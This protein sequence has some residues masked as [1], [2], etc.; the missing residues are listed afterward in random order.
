MADKLH[1]DKLTPRQEKAII[2][3]LNEPSIRKAA[4]TADVPERTLYAWLK[5]DQTFNDAYYA[6]RREAMSQA[7]ARLQQGST[8]AVN[9][10][11][12]IMARETTPLPL[13]LS[14]AKAVLDYAYRGT[15]LE[16]LAMRVALL[17]ALNHEL[18]NA[19]QS[20]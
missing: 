6:A 14:A 17:E 5:T 7:T 2:G 15:E 20:A 12:T 18:Q 16:D 10:I 11:L 19:T 3:L 9:I 13:R 8:A 4:I 1:N